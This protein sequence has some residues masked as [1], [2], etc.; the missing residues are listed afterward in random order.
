MLGF[1][2]FVLPSLS[3]A[4]NP[5][6]LFAFSSNFRQALRML[7]LFPCRFANSVHVVNTSVQER[8]KSTPDQAKS[9]QAQ[10]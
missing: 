7:N 9:S 4:I 1:T 2:Y 8:G 10:C 6:I 3:T 5:V